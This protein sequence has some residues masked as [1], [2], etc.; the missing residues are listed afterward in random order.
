MSPDA[1]PLALLL[2][3]SHSTY[4]ANLC[5]CT[6]TFFCG[7]LKWHVAPSAANGDRF[8]GRMR[9][10]Y[11][12]TTLLVPVKGYS[13]I[14]EKMMRFQLIAISALLLAPSIAYSSIFGSVRGV[15]HDPQHRPIQGARVTL[16]A[17]NSDWTKSQDSNDSGEFEFGSVPI[18]NYTVTVSSKGFQQMGQAVIVQSDTSPVLHFELAIAG[19]KETV[20]VSGIPVEAT[21]DSVTPTRS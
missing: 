11:A 14:E 19:A 1:I 6:L 21:M 3:A 2:A 20:S 13:I 9:V 17:Q 16:K 15:V 5:W 18:G 4:L 7:Q 10:C 8:V 12:Y